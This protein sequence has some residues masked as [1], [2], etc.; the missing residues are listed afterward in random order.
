MSEK[1]LFSN[2][3]CFVL[4]EEKYIDKLMEK[5]PEYDFDLYD[6]EPEFKINLPN[7]KRF[8]ALMK[9]VKYDNFESL[10]VFINACYG[11]YAD[12][13]SESDD[14]G[15]DAGPAA[16]GGAASSESEDEEDETAE[17]DSKFAKSLF[18]AVSKLFFEDSATRAQIETAISGKRIVKKFDD[19]LDKA[20]LVALSTI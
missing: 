10:C 14:E 4:H 1:K 3:F 5:L 6:T 12:F 19:D 16:K 8:V 2:L 13:Q 17:Q 15:D 9:T 20:M 18:R 7:I 11:E